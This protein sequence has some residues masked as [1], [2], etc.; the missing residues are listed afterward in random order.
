MESLLTAPW[1][2]YDRIMGRIFFVFFVG[3]YCFLWFQVEEI[4]IQ[5]ESLF[6]VG[7]WALQLCRPL[8]KSESPPPN[9][10]DVVQTERMWVSSHSQR[11]EKSWLFL[12]PW[13]SCSEFLSKPPAKNNKSER[14]NLLIFLL[15]STDAMLDAKQGPQRCRRE[16]LSTLHRLSWSQHTAWGPRHAFLSVLVILTPLD[17]VTIFVCFGSMQWLG[18][19]QEGNFLLYRPSKAS[20][21]MKMCEERGV[22]CSK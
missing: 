20:Y 4:E 2:G 17:C 12:L 16:F 1:L 19:F 10:L 6:V 3:E 22:F 5:W 21:K 11:L 18:E 13:F 7:L 8:S 9:L 14:K 15:P